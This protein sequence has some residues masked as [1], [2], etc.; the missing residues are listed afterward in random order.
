MAYAVH[1]ITSITEIPALWAA[2]AASAGFIVDNSVPS[3][4]TIKHPGYAGGLPFRM[5]TSISGLNHDIRVDSAT[6]V[7]NVSVTRSPILNPTL[8]T[9]GAAAVLPTKVHFIGDTTGEPFLATVVE[10]GF[11]LYRHVYVGYME[12]SSSYSGGEVISGSNFAPTELGSGVQS[13]VYNAARSIYQPPFCVSTN[14][15]AGG[16]RVVHA[17]SPAAWRRFWATGTT[18]SATISTFASTSRGVTVLGGWRDNVNTGYANS[19]Q[20]NFSSSA[21]LSPVNLLITKDN[22]GKTVFQQIGRVSGARM[23]NVRNIEPGAQVAVGSKNWIVFPCISKRSDPT[24]QQ[25]SP[26]SGSRYPN[27]NNSSHEGMAYRIN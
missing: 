7:T 24:Y 16:V 19:G 9:G 27:I 13:T 23:V 21:I 8:T 6:V 14:L 1:A 15:E 3:A 17:N 25:A 2:F 4:P 12:K 5:Q 11:N 20:S 18:S 10:Y 22:S 26:A